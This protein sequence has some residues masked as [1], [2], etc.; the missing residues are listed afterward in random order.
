MVGAVIGGF[1]YDTLIRNVLKA[2]GVKPDP[3]MVAAGEDVIDRGG[4]AAAG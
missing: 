1:I 3:E 2:R 4:Q